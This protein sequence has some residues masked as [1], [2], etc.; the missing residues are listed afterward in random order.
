M[1]R[2]GSRWLLVLV[3]AALVPVWASG[4]SARVGRGD[5][6]RTRP[7]GRA[8]AIVDNDDRMDA[9]SLDMVVTNHGSFAYDLLTGNAGL[10]YPKGSGHTVVFAGGIWIAATVGGQ[11]RTAIGEYFQ[12]YVPGPM[13]GGTYQADRP[14]FRNYRIG[15]GGAGYSDYLLYAVPQGAPVDAQGI[16]LLYGDATIWSVFNDADPA[17]HTNH[18]GST[19]PLGI[20]VQ[21]TVFALNRPGPLGNVIFVKWKL[22]NKGANTLQDAYVSVWSDPDVGGYTDDIVGCDTTLALGYCYNA[23]NSDEQYGSSPPAVGFQLLR[24]PVVERSPGVYDTLGLV[25]FSKYIN[26][27]DPMSPQETYNYMR[28]LHADGTPVHEYDDPA[29]PITTFVTSG[30]PVS[31]TGWLDSNPADRRMQLATGPFTMAPGDTQEVVTA[32]LVGRGTDRLG[33]ITELRSIA[34]VI[35]GYPIE[36]APV[37]SIDAPAEKTV[38]EGQD[39]AFPVTSHDPAGTA[40]LSFSG[41]P[42]GATFT[43]HGDGTGSFQ[44]TPGYNQAG[45]YT[46]TFTAHGTDGST[47]D[48]VTVIHVLDVNRKPVADAGGPYVAYVGVPVLFDGSVSLDPDGDPLSY[49]WNFG[50]DASG[51]GPTPS[52]A[53][54]IPGLYGIALSVSDGLLTDV[55]TTTAD[56]VERFSARAFTAAGN[57]TIRLA[58]GKPQWCVQIEPVGRSFDVSSVDPA[59]IVMISVGTGMVDRITAIAGKASVGADRDG[60]GIE[61]LTVCFAKD[62]LRQLF[63]ELQGKQS[64]PVTVEG[65]VVTGGE[66]RAALDV[67]VI[68]SGGPLAASVEPNPFSAGGTLRFLTRIPGRVT[69]SLFDSGGRLVRK[70]WESAE[71]GPGLHR[72]PLNGRD[73]AGRALGSGVYFYRI[74]APGGIATGRVLLLR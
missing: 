71:V 11:L 20:E 45:T 33:S 54:A 68:A 70:V 52:H 2:N 64:V 51:A 43:D 57:R 10:V 31:G 61:E 4:I 72:V 49:V 38:G 53:Y 69:V 40:L 5:T 41:V 42:L 55:A 24:S 19:A 21:Q 22:R 6:G 25:A 50:D 63:S 34:A 66:F 7:P 47:V 58:A 29:Q 9:N 28:G 56:I 23:T 27:T 14:E 46:V 30:D 15:Q 59:S 12:E 36:P 13:S 74:E 60:N 39:L 1:R 32:I 26:G 44:W 62:D 65:V 37:L 18:A 35:E 67:A 3:A 73:A 8:P 16:P 17:I 48:A